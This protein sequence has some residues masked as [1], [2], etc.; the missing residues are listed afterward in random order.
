MKTIDQQLE[1]F[2]PEWARLVAD[3]KP[4]PGFLITK[5]DEP[6]NGEAFPTEEAAWAEIERLDAES[7]KSVRGYDVAPVSLCL[8]VGFTPETDGREASWSYQTGDNSYSGGAYGHPHWA[9]V[10]ITAESD[11]AEV[12][13]EI[14]EEIGSLVCQ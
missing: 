4:E 14:A 10:W 11:P 3:L 8:T 9:V 12:A 6:I 13:S 5:Y 7:M 2:L 1:S